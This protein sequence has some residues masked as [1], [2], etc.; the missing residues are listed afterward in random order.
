MDGLIGELF[1]FIFTFMIGLVLVGGIVNGLAKLAVGECQ[2]A[3][4]DSIDYVRRARGGVHVLGIVV[5]TH[6]NFQEVRLSTMETFTS[7]WFYKRKWD[8][9]KKKY[10]GKKV[11]IYVNPKKPYKQT[12]TREMCWR[13]FLPITLSSLF[14]LFF[15]VY[16]GLDMLMDVTEILKYKDWM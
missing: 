5:K 7:W 1:V 14:L 3:V 10:I 6:I 4:I 2:E 12:I 15:L 13:Y 16:F 8:R 11:H 9:L